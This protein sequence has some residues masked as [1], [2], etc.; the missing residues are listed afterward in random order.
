MPATDAPA[1]AAA[2]LPARV[3][4]LSAVRCTAACARARPLSALRRA[5]CSAK[6]CVAA[7]V[8]LRSCSWN[9]AMVWVPRPASCRRWRTSTSSAR[10]AW[11]FRVSRSASAVALP[12]FCVSRAL[13]ESAACTARVRRPTRSRAS[14]SAEAVS[15]MLPRSLPNCLVRPCARSSA[16][17][18]SRVAFI[19]RASSL[20]ALSRSRTGRVALS[21][22]CRTTSRRRR[23]AWLIPGP[24]YARGRA[25]ATPSAP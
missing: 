5:S 7:P 18:W 11:N 6:A 9:C 8:A 16:F 1:P 4:I 19:E 10:C 17:M 2:K 22:A 20:L 14:R 13:G 3:R 21:T 25:R 15:R 12:R 23:R 24:R